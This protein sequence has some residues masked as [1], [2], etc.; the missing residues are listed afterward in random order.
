MPWIYSW[1]MTFL[2]NRRHFQRLGKS[3][4]FFVVTSLQ[5]SVA[6]VSEQTEGQTSFPEADMDLAFFLASKFS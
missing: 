4:S 5:F 2:P 3:L 1:F 6:A